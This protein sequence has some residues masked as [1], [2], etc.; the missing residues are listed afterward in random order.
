[1]SLFS[2]KLFKKVNFFVFSIRP[3]TI[4]IVIMIHS[5]LRIT[6]NHLSILNPQGIGKVRTVSC[7]NVVADRP[8]T[9]KLAIDN[10]R[11]YQIPFENSLKSGRIDFPT[12]PSTN[13]LLLQSQ[14]Q[15]DPIYCSHYDYQE[16][17]QMSYVLPINIELQRSNFSARS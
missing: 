5:Q 10:R 6:F 14:K 8:T 15:Q 9:L 4:S 12:P 2:N 7:E 11:A 16:P 13:A 3:P 17:S 1:L